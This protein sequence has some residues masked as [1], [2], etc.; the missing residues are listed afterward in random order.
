M[1]FNKNAYQIVTN[2]HCLN[3]EP[4]GRLLPSGHKKWP[5]CLVRM[6]FYT[7]GTGTLCKKESVDIRLCQ[8]LPTN[9][10]LTL[11]LHLM[12]NDNLTSFVCFQ[13]LFSSHWPICVRPSLHLLLQVSLLVRHHVLIVFDELQRYF[14]YALA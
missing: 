6:D 7:V 9:L 1:Q 13:L 8:R 2:C 4:D 10:S 12:K 3:K 11:N 5:F 14:Q